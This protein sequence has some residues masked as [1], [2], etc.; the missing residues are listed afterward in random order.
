MT[1]ITIAGLDPFS[2]VQDCTFLGAASLDTGE[3]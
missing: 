1:Y 2:A 3:G